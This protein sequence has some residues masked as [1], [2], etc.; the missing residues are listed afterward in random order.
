ML[1]YPGIEVIELISQKYTEVLS[2]VNITMYDLV[3]WGAQ[4][5]LLNGQIIRSLTLDNPKP[6]KSRT[7]DPYKKIPLGLAGHP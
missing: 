2:S 6:K 3:A 5:L 1:T 7:G 4:A